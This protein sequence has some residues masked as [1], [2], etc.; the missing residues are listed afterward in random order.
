MPSS[1]GAGKRSKRAWCKK[2]ETSALIEEYIIG[3]VQKGFCLCYQSAFS[4]PYALELLFSQSCHLKGITAFSI[5]SNRNIFTCS[6]AVDI[7]VL[8]S[9]KNHKYSTEQVT[10]ATHDISNNSNILQCSFMWSYLY[11]RLFLLHVHHHVLLYH[12]LWEHLFLQGA[13][14]KISEEVAALLDQCRTVG[15]ESH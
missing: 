8:T 7:Q 1:K 12:L 6:T 14:A 4:P 15:I 13:L 9:I 10:K 3:D 2:K 11:H 5:K